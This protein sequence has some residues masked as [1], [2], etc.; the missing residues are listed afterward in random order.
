MKHNPYLAHMRSWVPCSVPHMRESE[1][2][3]INIHAN[4]IPTSKYTNQIS[5]HLKGEIDFNMKIAENSSQRF[6]ITHQSSRQKIKEETKDLQPTAQC[7]L[8]SGKQYPPG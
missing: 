4:N 1:G 6:S 3:R 8:F 7:T 2:E 5:K